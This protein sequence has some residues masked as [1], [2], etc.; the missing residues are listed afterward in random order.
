[1][2]KN[3]NI[4]YGRYNLLLTYGDLIKYYNFTSTQD[5]DKLTNPENNNKL[6]FNIKDIRILLESENIDDTI[7]Q[8]IYDSLNIENYYSAFI[9]IKDNKK[10]NIYKLN[11]L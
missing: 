4:R 1:M 3:W 2:T 7:N 10:Y 5:I 8:E 11:K 9:E 6:I